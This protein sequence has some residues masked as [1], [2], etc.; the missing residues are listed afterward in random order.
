MDNISEYLTDYEH[1][2]ENLMN[3]DLKSYG[4]KY[5]K[6]QFFNGDIDKPMQKIWL[7]LPK[8]K[9]YNTPTVWKSEKT[10]FVKIQ[11]AI[12]SDMLPII[13]FIKDLENRTL[14]IVRKLMNN[15]DINCESSIIEN[16]K[17]YSMFCLQLP[18]EQENDAHLYTIPIFNNRNQLEQ[19]IELISGM[20]VAS[21][22]ELTDVWISSIKMGFN[23]RV[24][25]M[26]VY[27]EFDFSKCLFDTQIPLPPPAP[28]TIKKSNE[29]NGERKSPK[30]E[31]F[32][33]NVSDLINMKKLLKPLNNNES[34]DTHEIKKKKK[35]KSKSKKNKSIES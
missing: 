30:P 10:S 26:K 5:S 27:P 20:F 17:F 18:Y 35:S 21:Y 3:D 2:I 14:K 11:L 32:V 15:N 25:Q 13:T 6:I 31:L 7:L 24:L 29:K 9:L 22:I 34:Y 8:M 33:P 4:N 12:H 16:P 19:S 28:F 23:W 1:N